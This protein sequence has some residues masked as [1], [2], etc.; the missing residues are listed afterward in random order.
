MVMKQSTSFLILAVI[1]VCLVNSC[2]VSHKK[3][4]YV[5]KNYQEIKNAFPNATITLVEDSIKVIFPNNIVFE[6]GSA[7]L[8]DAFSDR[9]KRFSEILLKFDK[10]N[11][12]INGHTDNSGSEEA[13]INLSL[14]RA[15]NVKTL[16]QGKSINPTRLFTWGFG[17]KNPIASNSTETGRTK[18]RRVEFVV[19]YN[20]LNR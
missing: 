4:R 5:K 6:I 18:N 13:N 7:D 14:Q 20:T 12:L 15:N 1:L 2:G 9:M 10:T 17:E 16:L 11:L 3:N 19:L 8:K